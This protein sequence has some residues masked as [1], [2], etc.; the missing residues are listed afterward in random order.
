M[1]EP[2]YEIKEIGGRKTIT[3][4][5]C[6]RTSY[7]PR[8]VEEKYCGHCHRFHDLAPFRKEKEP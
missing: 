2:T 7:H 6:G 4:L 8:D 3:C 5:V 1:S